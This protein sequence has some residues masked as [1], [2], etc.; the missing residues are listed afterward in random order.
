[1]AGNLFDTLIRH[2]D[3]LLWNLE[4]Q[5]NALA[6]MHEEAARIS[7]RILQTKADLAE[8]NRALDIL[9]DEDEEV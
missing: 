5:E 4:N 3:S 6:G 2:R 8:A 7:S 9:F 1:M